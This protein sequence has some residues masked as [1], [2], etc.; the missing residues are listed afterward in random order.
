MRR[1][2]PVLLLLIATLASGCATRSISNSG[3][4]GDTSNSFYRGELSEF[5]VLGID[6]KTTASDSEIAAQFVAYQRISLHRGQPIMVVQ[7]GAL[8]PDEPMLRELDRFFT[9]TPFSGIPAEAGAPGSWRTAT[10]SDAARNYAS[11]LR[12]AAA[13]GGY[14][15]VLCYWGVLETA[16]EGHATKLVSWV[17]IVGAAV[18]DET[19]RMQIR[20]RVALIDVKSG[21]WAMFSPATFSDT[22]LTA[23]FVR[24][25]SDQDQV[26]VLKEQ[27]YKAAVE[28]LVARYVD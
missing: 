2:A 20:L 18:P 9:T 21:R 16:V 27:A 22:A 25:S 4:P 24:R 8:L 5:D 15:T 13:K 23:A 17:P 14:E 12:L 28:K 11:L 6:P 10:N 19:Q 3:Y 7:S 26:A 1:L